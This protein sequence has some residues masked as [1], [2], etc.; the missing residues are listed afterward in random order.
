MHN[1]TYQARSSVQTG[2]MLTIIYLDF[3]VRALPA[4]HTV[5]CITALTRIRA[6][7]SISTWRMMSAEIEV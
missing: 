3:A 7:R 6:C 5:T 4:R 2:L 1:S